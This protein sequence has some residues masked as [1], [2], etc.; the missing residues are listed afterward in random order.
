MILLFLAL[1]L[2]DNKIASS[3]FRIFR[4]LAGVTDSLVT[5]PQL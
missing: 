2:G 4:E 3:P 1:V 5:P